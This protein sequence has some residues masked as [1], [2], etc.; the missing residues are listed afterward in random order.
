MAVIGLLIGDGVCF[1]NH[2]GSSDSQACQSKR[3]F[4]ATVEMVAAGH[5]SVMAAIGDEGGGSGK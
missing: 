3:L 2:G 4:S 1:L 5:P